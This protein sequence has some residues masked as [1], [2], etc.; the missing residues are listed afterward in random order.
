[1]IH[2]EGDRQLAI[3][4]TDA[5]T[6]LRDARFLV[7]CIQGA[8]PSSEPASADEAQCI[9][10]PNLPFARGATVL[11]LKI[12]ETDE[13]SRLCVMVLGQGANFASE[14]ETHLTLSEHQG[15]TRVHWTADVKKLGG[16]LQMAPSA[17]VHAAAQKITQEVWSLVSARIGR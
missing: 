9:V 4:P 13:P 16:M 14:V 3:T 1:M 2:F 17:Q 15:G 5:W 7:E 11:T 8:Q 10:R 12:A 6:K